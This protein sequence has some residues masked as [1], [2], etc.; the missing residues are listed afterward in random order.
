[1]STLTVSPRGPLAGALPRPSSRARAF[2]LDA[3]LVVAGAAVVALLAQAEIPLWPVP[4]TGQTLAVVLVGAS[5]GVRRGGLALLTY[6]FAG[7]AGLPVFAG[8]SGSIAAVA[9]PSFG[10][11]VGFIPA[12]M[13]AGYAAA[14][15]GSAP[16]DRVRRLRRGKHCSVLA[17]RSVHGVH[18]Q[19]GDGCR[20]LGCA[21]L[22]RRSHAVHRRRAHQ[23]SD[24]RRRNSARVA[25]CCGP[26]P[27]PRLGLNKREWP[28]LYEMAIRV[29]RL[30][31]RLTRRPYGAPPAAPALA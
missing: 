29:R 14:R 15:M 11:I 9:S 31:F 26:R 21:D 10:F 2:A 16:P 23:G 20:T 1:M 24:C 28:S 27:R 6:L 17:R 30:R 7:L 18:P 19:Y 13:V 5:L 22:R 4:I 12:A 25:G 8:F 3:A